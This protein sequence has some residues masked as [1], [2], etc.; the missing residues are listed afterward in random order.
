MI[1][2]KRLRNEFSELIEHNNLPRFFIL[3]GE[4]GSG[5]Q[6]LIKWII[7]KFKETT[8]CFSCREDT[9]VDTIRDMIVDAYKQAGNPVFYIIP[10]A[11]NMSLAAKNALLKVTEEPPNQAYFIMTLSNEFNTLATIKSRATLF[12]MDTYTNEDLADFMSTLPDM[13]REEAH[14]LL[15]MCSTIG[16][17]KKVREYGTEDF[18]NFTSKV[19]DSLSGAPLAN[20]LKICSSMSTKEDDGKYDIELFWVAYVRVSASRALDSKQ[21]YGVRVKYA[22]NIL[23]T[24]YYLRTLRMVTGI[25][26]SQLFDRWILEILGL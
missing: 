19:V 25:N 7:R 2:Q 17:I 5:R 1:G 21:D 16:G 20:S 26:K 22:Q 4:Q 23:T 8:P 10:N 13:S 3:V 24:S 18:Y 14:Q 12:K 15:E 6:E 9:K 11:D